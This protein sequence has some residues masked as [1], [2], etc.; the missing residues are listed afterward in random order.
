MIDV[1]E[2]IETERL[3]LRRPRSGD[4]PA[5]NAAIL[6]SL[7][8]LRPW[9]PWAKDVP[10]LEDSESYVRL[11]RARFAMRTDLPFH[12][13]LASDGDDGPLAGVIALSRMDWNVPRFEIG[14]WRCSRFRQRGVMTEAVIGLSRMAFDALGANR[15]ELRIEAGNE[16]SWRVAERAGFTLDGVLRRERLSVSGELSD[17]RVYSRVRGVEES[18]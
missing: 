14:Y 5:L 6:A 12:I 13:R 11:T 8:E 15:V 17:M 4:G 2:G 18:A 9:A 7:D 16:R 3:V 1:P 10:S